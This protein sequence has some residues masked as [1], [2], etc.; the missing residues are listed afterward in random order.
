MD[1]DNPGPG[2]VVIRAA[3]AMDKGDAAVI[4]TDS[5]GTI[6]YWNEPATRLY[7][8]GRDEVLDRNIV[9]VTPATQSAAEA[10]HIM[11]ELLTGNPWSGSFLVRHK[12][13]T[14]LIVDVTDIPILTDGGVA[15]IVGISH[16][17]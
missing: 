16:S 15:G 4:A 2:D 9:D 8:W 10:Q 5:A 17:T 3:S 12:D 14:P 11:H 7:G 13:G 1:K 6:I